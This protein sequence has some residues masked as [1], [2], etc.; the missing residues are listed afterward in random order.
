[1]FTFKFFGLQL[2]GSDIPH[3]TT[4]EHTADAVE[5]VLCYTQSLILK[6]KAEKFSEIKV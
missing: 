6:Y 1:L 2:L 3:R 5:M 4:I